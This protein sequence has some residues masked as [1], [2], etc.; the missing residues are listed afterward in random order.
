MVEN[1]CA[2]DVVMLPM[3]SMT[4]LV[5]VIE[6]KAVFVIVVPADRTEVNV[7]D[8]VVVIVERAIFVR[9]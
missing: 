1:A 6:A 9:S 3:V 8:C 2:T 4:V 5:S 7:V